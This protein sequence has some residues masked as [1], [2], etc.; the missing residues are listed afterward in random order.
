MYGRKTKKNR[1]LQAY[2]YVLACADATYYVGFSRYLHNRLKLHWLGKAAFFTRKHRPLRLVEWRPAR[3][4]ADEYEA[5]CEYAMALGHKNVGGY[6]KRLCA[7]NGFPW[8]F[9]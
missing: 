2:V 5:W 1:H 7:Q 6:S 3:N 4:L 9:D 8:L